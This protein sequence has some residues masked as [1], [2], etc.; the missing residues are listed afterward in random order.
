MTVI[1]F[2][3][4]VGKSALM[5]K[6]L[7]KAKASLVSKE[8]PPSPA[9]IEIL[10]N[11][12]QKP[13]DPRGYTMSVDFSAQD[14]KSVHAVLDHWGKVISVFPSDH[15]VKRMSRGGWGGCLRRRRLSIFSSNFH[16]FSS[17]I[18]RVFSFMSFRIF[19]S[20]F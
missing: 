1:N 18:G 8:I 7:E 15:D 5:S 9:S 13:W 6:I 4:S 3:R 11:P 17:C 14:G 20:C 12:Q 2:P 10:K 16:F 19:S